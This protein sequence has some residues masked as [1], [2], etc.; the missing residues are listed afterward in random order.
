MKKCSD[1]SDEYQNKE[2]SARE[3]FM[4]RKAEVHLSNDNVLIPFVKMGVEARDQVLKDGMM[5]DARV[6]KP[7]HPLVR[8]AQ[9]FTRN[10]DLIAER[11][12]VIFHLRELAKASVLAKFLVD[13]NIN[14]D[15][16]WFNLADDTKIASPLEI[17]MLW[18]DRMHSLVPVKDG[19]L[20]SEQISAGPKQHSI[21]G[22]VDFGLNR[23][24]LT[25]RRAG[26]TGMLEGTS[27]GLAAQRRVGWGPPGRRHF[28]GPPMT[29]GMAPPHAMTSGAPWLVTPGQQQQPQGVDLNLNKFDLSAATRDP[30]AGDFVSQTKGALAPIGGAFWANIFGTSEQLFKDEDASLLWDIFN[31]RLCDRRD[32][33]SEFVPPVTDAANVGRLRNLVKDEERVR[34][35]RIA[36]FLSDKFVEGDAGPLFPTSWV[37]FAEIARGQ[38]PGQVSE[39]Q[40]HKQGQL[41]I[42][43]DY[44]IESSVLED[45][46]KS[47]VPVF[48]KSTEEGIRFRIYRFGTLEVRTT[49]EPDGEEAIGVVFSIR[50]AAQ[51]GSGAKGRRRAN[52]DEKVVKATEYVERGR[53]GASGESMEYE[54]GAS[55]RGLY[56]RYYVAL[57][58]EKGNVLVSEMAGDATVTWEENPQDLEDRNSLARVFRSSDCSKVSITVRDVAAYRAREIMRESQ[59]SRSECKRYSHGLYSRVTGEIYRSRHVADK[60]FTLTRNAPVAGGWQSK[61]ASLGQ[62]VEES[63]P[64]DQFQH[65]SVQKVRALQSEL[66]QG[67][68]E[69]EFQAKLDELS[70]RFPEGKSSAEFRKEQQLVYL[71]VQ[72]HVLPKY[73]FE[74]SGRGVFEMLAILD[75]FTNDPQMTRGREELAAVLKK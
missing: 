2:W 18:N 74:G 68:K 39:V 67:F 33:G 54:A 63:V 55:R 69:P 22:G 51:D 27:A 35:A 64:E 9:E 46:M 40:R 28:V 43:T 58:T 31:P 62:K 59:A 49:E 65:F 61:M 6:T 30:T 14:L 24:N 73:G 57:E 56:R 19:K 10:F 29:T 72:A 38:A 41:H 21:Y 48:D 20:A 12:S 52:E 53:Q 75:K 66:L 1:F 13:S 4:V 70:A 15:A 45:V 32:D 44:I 8:Y 37:P 36:H 23:F 5:V 50:T 60:A 42:R 16:T 71:T 47:V 26:G 17:P 25:A 11:K 34:K 3:W 7:N